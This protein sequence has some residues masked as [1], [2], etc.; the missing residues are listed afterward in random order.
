MTREVLRE[1]KAVRKI[2]AK[3]GIR[4][5]SEPGGPVKAQGERGAG[6]A[7]RARDTHAGRDKRETEIL[8]LR[9]KIGQLVVERVS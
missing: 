8:K 3:H 7:I 6:M 4:G 9:E 2:A 5:A 1:A